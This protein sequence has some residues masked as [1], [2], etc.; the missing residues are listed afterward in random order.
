MKPIWEN[1]SFGSFLEPLIG[2]YTFF[3]KRM[4]GGLAIYYEGKMV[5]VFMEDGDQ[6]SYKDVDFGWP[7]WNGI[8][9]PTFKE[10][11]PS[12]IQEFSALKEHPVLK[13]W[14]YLSYPQDSFE[15]SAIQLVNLIKKQDPRIGI[16]PQEKREASRKKSGATEKKVVHGKKPK[17]SKR[18]YK[19]KKKLTLRKA[20][21]RK[22]KE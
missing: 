4:F 6:T 14:M 5:L 8:L 19:S 11:H 16:W 15:E 12:L 10:F 2:S 9:I 3:V 1:Y 20:P 21:K 18:K 7:I 13:K 17:N 22:T